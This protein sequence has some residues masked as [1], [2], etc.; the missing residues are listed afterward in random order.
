MNDR[1]RSARLLGEI[2]LAS[3][4]SALPS[5]ETASAASTLARGMTEVRLRAGEVLYRQGGLPSDLF[6]IVEGEVRLE[7]PGLPQWTMAERSL[8]GAL[9]VQLDRPRS[10][11]VTATRDTRLLRVPAGDWLDLLEDSAE[12]ARTGIE[13]LARGLHRARLELDALGLPESVPQPTR[14]RAAAFG[15]VD[16]I[17]VLRGVPLLATADWQSLTSLAQL[18][19]RADLEPGETIGAGGMPSDALF[20]VVVGSVLA[21]RPGIDR[22]VAYGPGALVLGSATAAPTI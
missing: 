4:M 14:E 8:I 20:V 12:M 13:N 19:G 9:D 3:F 7:A 1:D 2:F 16:R 21:S 10:R 17:V 18:A 5:A 22:R 11:T 6:F 15:L